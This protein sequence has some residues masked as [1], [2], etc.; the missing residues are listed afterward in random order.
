MEINQILKYT[1][2]LNVLFVEDDN[3]AREELTN[4]FKRFFNSVVTACNGE[5]GL[6]KFNSDIDLV[7]TDI[8]MPKMN[9]LDMIIKIKTIEPNINTIILSAYN[10]TEYFIN[11]ILIGVN[12]FMLKPF[13][14][15]Q[16]VST[17]NNIYKDLELQKKLK[18]TQ[19]LLC[20][21]QQ[22]VD[23]SIIVCKFNIDKNIT[24][25]N[26][27]FEKIFKYENLDNEFGKLLYQE[28]IEKIYSTIE[29]K[30]IYKNMA[31]IISQN[32]EIFY[33]K[34]IIKPILDDNNEIIEYIALFLD[35]G[36]IL[37]AKQ[38]L[39]DY[40]EYN[41][42]ILLGAFYLVDFDSLRQYFGE[43]II[44]N[45]SL[46]LE[47]ILRKL[48]PQDIHIYNL[49]EGKFVLAT[50]IHSNN[51]SALIKIY[52]KIQTIL[53]QKTI[54][55]DNFVYNVSTILS[56][57]SGEKILEK[58]YLG[59]ENMLKNNEVFIE[60]DTLLQLLTTQAQNNLQI[61]SLLKDS[62]DNNYI[63]SYH[64][65]I[66][67]NE[68]LKP[69]K[70]EALVRIQTQDKLYLP[71]QF[72]D[73]AKH[74]VYYSQITKLMLEYN[75]EIIKRYNIK[76][77]VNIAINDI[78]KENIRMNIYEI[79]EKYRSYTSNLTF[80]ILEDDAL[81][82]YEILN[83]FIT[84]IKKYNIKI[85]LDDFGSGYSNFSRVLELQP[86]ILKIDGSLIKNIN[87]SKYSFNLVKTMV[88]FAK[89]N[90][91]KT[92]AEFVENEEIFNTIKKLGIDYSQGYYFAKPEKLF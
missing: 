58:A 43:K 42:N 22:I 7:I 75:L 28:N 53:N 20:Q 78:L 48:T 63:I 19:Y 14:L 34:L 51:K 84:N 91:I 29:N 35:V 76:V 55:I 50:T 70:Y 39:L 82:S 24:Y 73:I 15:D 44:T 81:E 56:V 80:E 61:I 33:S 32:N 25:T 54:T 37:D 21:Y 69:I 86:D 72:L 90:N 30:H 36:D 26:E 46:E 74:S 10:E 65:A 16:F 17:L 9:G 8:N 18:D 85:S 11:A 31:K 38:I 71:Y 4:I 77:S 66:I 57:A 83:K 23:K 89:L 92:I 79:L 27:Q 5:E 88:D 64:Q 6:K 49:N 62:I 68:T 47:K 3:V 41:D 60:S 2:K 59:I 45:L 67:D 1:K 52:Q 87:D 12:G 40:I 13:V